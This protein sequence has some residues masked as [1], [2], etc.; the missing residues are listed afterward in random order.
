[1]GRWQRHIALG[2]L[3]I[4]LAGC[5]S[6]AALS[7]NWSKQGATQQAV[8]NNLRECAQQAELAV[9]TQGIIDADIAASR[10]A[11]WRA[12]GTYESN[13]QYQRDQTYALRDRLIGR[14]MIMR[15]FLIG[16]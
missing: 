16:Q 3:G 1:M 11:D 6:V 15:G 5:A 7:E 12:G 4:V 14:C 8:D 2:V 10:E 9:R 13:V